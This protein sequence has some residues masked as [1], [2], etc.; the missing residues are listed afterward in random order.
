MVSSIVSNPAL[1][2]CNFDDEWERAFSLLIPLLDFSL[3]PPKHRSV[4][5]VLARRPVLLPAFVKI[6]LVLPPDSEA[7]AHKLRHAT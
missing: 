1:A 4:P 2:P 3:L 5:P 7:S 6:R